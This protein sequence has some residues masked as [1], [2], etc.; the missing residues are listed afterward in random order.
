MGHSMLWSYRSRA[1]EATGRV[2]AFVRRVCS[3]A[4]QRRQIADLPDYILE[5]VGLTPAE[6][7]RE[8][9][10]AFWALPVLR[11]HRW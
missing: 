8:A 4:D 11:S 2:M 3:M 5:D 7:R 10:S 9:P 1:M 6:A